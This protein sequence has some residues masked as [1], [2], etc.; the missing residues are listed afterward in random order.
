MEITTY[1]ERLLETIINPKGIIFN[2]IYFKVI[3]EAIE[4]H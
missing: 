3:N 2:S 4:I 1:N